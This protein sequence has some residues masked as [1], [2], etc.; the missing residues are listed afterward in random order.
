MSR[1]TVQG[2]LSILTLLAIVGIGGGLFYY[3]VPLSGREYFIIILTWLVTK[4][5]TS[6]D[7]YFGSSQGSA[8]KTSIINNLTSAANGSAPKP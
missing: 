7:Y 2:I 8:D 6:Y 1:I 5:G 4:G 3:Q